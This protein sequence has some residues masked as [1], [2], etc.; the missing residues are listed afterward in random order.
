MIQIWNMAPFLLAT[1]CWT[2]YF[3]SLSLSSLIFKLGMK[4]IPSFIAV[5]ALLWGLTAEK[6]WGTNSAASTQETQ[7]SSVFTLRA[8]EHPSFPSTVSTADRSPPQ[9][10]RAS[11]LFIKP[12]D[13]LS[14]PNGQLKPDWKFGA[15][16]RYEWGESAWWDWLRLPASLEKSERLRF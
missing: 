9:A 16:T 12:G 7:S 2:S 14:F 10:Q 4:M 1:Q 13:V 11:S 3:V 15:K 5:E 6:H 8:H